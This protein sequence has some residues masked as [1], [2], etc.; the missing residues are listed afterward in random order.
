MIDQLP[1]E[2]I[3]QILGH[4]PTLS[5]ILN[6]SSTNKKLHQVIT[7]G[8]NS[9]FHNFVERSFPTISVQ[10]PWREAAFNLA[11]RSRAWDRR[12]FIA[13]ECAAPSDAPPRARN[14]RRQGFGYAPV[15]DS[16]EAGSARTKG[17][18][19][20]LAWGAA[21]RLRLRTTEGRTVRWSSLRVPDDDRAWTDIL[22]V[23]LLRPHQNRNVNGES[24]LIRRADKEIVLLRSMPEP[25]KFVTASTYLANR[26]T[27]IDCLDVS[28]GANPQLAICNGTSIQLFP[29]HSPHDRVQPG[30]VLK[31]ANPTNLNQRKRCARFVSESLIAIGTQFLEGKL[32][33]PVE[34]FDVNAT[35]QGLPL[36]ALKMLEADDRPVRNNANVLVKVSEGTNAANMSENLLLAGSTDGLVRLYD[37]RAGS[38]PVRKYWDPVDDGQIFSLVPVG[39]EKFFA[40][41]HQN[42]CLKIFD[43]RMDARAYDYTDAVRYTSPKSPMASGKPIVPQMLPASRSRKQINIFLALTVHYAQQPWQPLPSVH[44]N[45]SRLPR[46]RGSIYSLSS[47][48]PSSR[49][50]YAGIENHVIQ[51]DFMNT[52]DYIFK[53]GNIADTIDERPI[54]NLSCYERPRKGFESTDTVLLRKQEDWNRALSKLG[55]AEPG[56]DERWQL[57]SA[58]EKR[59]MGGRTRWRR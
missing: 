30:A 31:L 43:M 57:E 15:I 23:R 24:I 44:E 12:A 4:L 19:E 13:R 18:K 55:E 29:V 46:Y 48:S 42:A 9:I 8:S 36:H 6:V 26:E 16:F 59:G 1:A 27:P 50:I 45:T 54:L 33:A 22:D 11:S 2:I 17:G 34:L 52:D 28:D 7:Q 56:W 25:D 37:L 3:E 14:D 41:S 39:Q 40:G 53:R 38:T 21:G 20:V 49:T 5:A 47:P 51:L 35:E 58:R 10:P 32:G